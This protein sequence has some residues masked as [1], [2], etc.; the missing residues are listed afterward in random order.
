MDW[1]TRIFKR[2]IDVAAASVVLVV[3][4]PLFPAIALAVKVTSRGP[5]FYGQT[6]CGAERRSGIAP[7]R[8]TQ[9]ERRRTRGYHT[10][11]MYKFRSMRVDAESKTGAVLAQVNDPRLTPIG[12]FLRKTRLDELPQLL[13]VLRGEMSMVGPRPERPELM[14]KLEDAV[15]FFQ[16][17]MRLIKPGITGLAQIKLNYDGSLGDDSESRLLA[18][19]LGTGELPPGSGPN[20]DTRMFANK[21]LYDLAYGAILENPMEWLKTDLEILLKTPLVM[22]LGKGR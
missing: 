2:A 20:D 14:A 21:M 6:R 22:I 10:F 5:V 11:Q 8:P 18:S 1:K 12:G 4:A 3:T 13:H 16:E 19:F 9:M 17:R 15:P 7:S